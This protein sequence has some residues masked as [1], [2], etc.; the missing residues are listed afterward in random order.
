[1]NT[2]I[3]RVLYGFCSPDLYVKSTFGLKAEQQRDVERC[4]ACISAAQYFVSTI[5]TFM[6]C[7]CRA[8]LECGTLYVG[9]IS[10]NL[11]T[12][13]WAV[14]MCMY[15]ARLYVCMYVYLSVGEKGSCLWLLCATAWYQSECSIPLFLLCRPLLLPL[16]A[17]CESAF[18]SMSN[19]ADHL[20]LY[21]LLLERCHDRLLALI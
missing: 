11:S 6:M 12:C 9:C 13:M 14:C 3:V 7:V 18:S 19:S 20:L 8:V 21:I 4:S 5:S 2:Q 1:M 10:V 15:V 17:D 16:R